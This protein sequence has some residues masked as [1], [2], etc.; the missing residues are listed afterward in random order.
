MGF[1][2]LLAAAL[3]VHAADVEL[4]ARLPT[5]VTGDGA[6]GDSFGLALTTS[7]EWLA[8]GAP[9]D[10]LVVP[11][12]ANGIETGSV[13]LY[14]RDAAGSYG[15]IAKLINGPLVGNGDNT[16]AAMAFMGTQIAVGIPRAEVDSVLESGLVK[17]F[18]FNNEGAVERQIL[19]AASPQI[20]ERYGFALAGSGN[21]LAVGVP[22]AGSGRVEVYVRGVAGFARQQV[23]TP[24]PGAGEV[25]FGHALAFNGTQLLIGA[26]QA[27]GGA[28]YGANWNGSQFSAPSRLAIGAASSTELGFAIAMLDNVAVVGAPGSDNG[29]ALLLS[30]DGS[31]WNLATTVAAQDGTPGMRFGSAVAVNPTRLAIGAFAALGGDGAVYAYSRAGTALGTPTRIDV[32]NGGTAD[33]FGIA[34]GFVGDE[35]IAG[36]DQASVGNNRGQGNARVYAPVGASWQAV[37]SIDT[38][39]GA[40]YDRYGT[41]VSVHGDIAVVG[42]YLEDTAAGAD[43]GNVHWFR[44]VGSGWRY[45]GAIPAPDE[46][47]EERYGIAVALDAERLIV[48]AYW[49]VIGNNLDQG[50]AYVFRRQGNSFVFE[51]KLTA[52]LGDEGHLFGFAVDID[53]DT[54]L[55]GARGA[56]GNSG[57][58]HLFHR[59]GGVWTEGATLAA[60]V[61]QSGAAFGASVALLGE[62]VV[63]GAPAATPGDVDFSGA[64]Y[65]YSRSG[66]FVRTLTAPAPSANSAFG[67]AVDTD[68]ERI[69][70]GAFQ[71]GAPPIVTGAAFV[72]SATTGA[73]ESTLTAVG[74]RPGDALGIAVA[75]DG[76]L[77]A[78]G[79]TG[80]DIAGNQNAGAVY[81]FRRAGSSWT[82]ESRLLSAAP[83]DGSGVGRSVALY[84]GTVL[85][86]A[87]GEAIDNPLEGTAF[88][89]DLERL[90]A[91]GFE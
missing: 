40:M 79:A 48:G 30:F 22:R 84:Q 26:P 72:Y 9:S 89:V 80:V 19:T 14:R 29:R 63:V 70:A 44:R 7:A 5:P 12:V 87:P 45:G 52:A 32:A 78:L 53:G 90:F 51:S 23:L 71:D 83:F 34:I 59:S 46:I 61:A 75:I 81:L 15:R 11:G 73:L 17:I 42:A 91:D 31:A 39:D 3:Q 66:A 68:G 76:D 65:Q 88:V 37:R 8:V 74:A 69:V 43:A 6:S 57:R 36:S 24:E 4:S 77:I 16:G 64:A 47:S 62:H 54:A 35:L 41:S 25:S 50:S 82:Q 58:A 56:F 85:T 2:L 10:T 18:S 86:G 27:G 60:P 38:G 13:I 20:D 33:R 49:D 1:T 28:V 67:F 55:V 21:V